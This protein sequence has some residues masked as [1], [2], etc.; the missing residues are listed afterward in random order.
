MERSA[1]PQETPL[2]AALNAKAFRNRHRGAKGSKLPLQHCLGLVKENNAPL[3]GLTRVGALKKDLPVLC[4]G[5]QASMG[6]GLQKARRNLAGAIGHSMLLSELCRATRGMASLA[7]PGDPE[8]DWRDRLRLGPNLARPAED[9]KLFKQACLLGNDRCRAGVEPCNGRL[10]GPLLVGKLSPLQPPNTGVAGNLV[11]SNGGLVV[12]TA[13]A[14]PRA[15]PAKGELI[16]ATDLSRSL[17]GLTEAVAD[18][19]LRWRLGRGGGT[20]TGDPT[21]HNRRRRTG[22]RGGQSAKSLA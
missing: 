4:Q 5:A 2:D 11:S 18:N 14:G 21:R 6:P 3:L 13:S 8:G 10:F 7:D 16:R 9:L 15:Q 20:T 12:V 19:R 22:S 17:Q 1:A